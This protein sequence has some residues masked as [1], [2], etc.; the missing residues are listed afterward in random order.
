MGKCGPAYSAVLPA[1]PAC[2]KTET[3]VGS[4]TV[5][6]SPEHSWCFAVVAAPAYKN[7]LVPGPLRM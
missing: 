4:L 6:A 3:R 5:M 7:R 1:V 2:A